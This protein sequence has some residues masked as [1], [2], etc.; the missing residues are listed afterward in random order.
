MLRVHKKAKLANKSVFGVLF[1]IY[2]LLIQS[3]SQTLN[4]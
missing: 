3:D 4:L 2:D 1:L